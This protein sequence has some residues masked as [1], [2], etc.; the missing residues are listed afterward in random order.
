M[1]NQVMAQV[2]GMHD[3]TCE[4][5]RRLR[6]LIRPSVNTPSITVSVAPSVPMPS[7]TSVEPPKDSA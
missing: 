7:I 1:Q 5:A 3:Q 6:A 4:T 2:Q